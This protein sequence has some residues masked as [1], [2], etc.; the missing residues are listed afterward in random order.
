MANKLTISGGLTWTDGVDSISA[1]VAISETPTGTHAEES[2]QNFD[3]TG[4]QID[5]AGVAPGYVLFKNK[6]VTNNAII[7]TANDFAVHTF[8]LKPGE[9]TIVPTAID[10]WYCKASAATIDLL[11]MVVDA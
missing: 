7:S 5:F 6:D 9:G 2:I 3:G 1:K 8:T 10:A 11:V 4:G